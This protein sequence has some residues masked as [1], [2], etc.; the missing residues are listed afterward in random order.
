MYTSIPFQAESYCSN[1]AFAPATSFFFSASSVFTSVGR[2]ALIL[3]TSNR[4]EAG[5]PLPGRAAWLAK[6]LPSTAVRSR[7]ATRASSFFMEQVLAEPAGDGSGPRNL[8]HNPI[9]HVP[10]TGPMET[11]AQ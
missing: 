4:S 1:A 2:T 5:E 10:V 11:H 8:A 7:N 6:G 9:H 3:V